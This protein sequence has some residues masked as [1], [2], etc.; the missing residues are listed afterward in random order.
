MRRSVNMLL[1]AV[2]SA[3]VMPV[4]AQLSEYDQNKPLGWGQTVTGSNDENPIT[5]TTRSALIS[6]L[7]GTAAK[8]IYVK[9][10]IE[11]TGI[12]TINGA[13]NK[14]I[15]GLPGS[16]LVNSEH[17][18]DSE[19]EHDENSKTD[20]VHVAAQSHSGILRLANCKNIILRNLTF[21]SA[22]AYDINGN[23]NLW[24]TGSSYIWVDHCDF[25]DGVDGNFDCSQGSDNI[26]VTW[27]RFRY[28]I[29]PWPG[30]CGGSD[31]HC[32]SDLWGGSD[33]ETASAGKLNTTFANCWWDEGC[34]E[35]MPRVRHGKVHLV[36]CLY[37]C[38]GNNY[39]VGAGYNSNLYVEKCAFV[40]VRDPWK[41]YATSGS[42]TNYNIT[43]TGN[44]GAD[45][46]QSRSGS[47]DYFI[48]TDYYTLDSYD[49]ALV[50]SVVSNEEN[51]AGATLDIKE[52]DKLTTGISQTVTSG[53]RITAT[54]YFTL[55]GMEASQP[56][57]G[58]NIVQEK[59][60]DGTVRARKVM[61]R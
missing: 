19:A 18:P 42:Y 12:Q 54:R 26:S 1:V 53:A 23:D 32:Y 25:Q 11:F 47:A 33:G 27:C 30:G 6:A 15:Y 3:M 50:Q 44:L 59:L 7:S 45:D 61:V 29:A 14:T 57:S 46:E 41:C 40:N 55:S 13:Q 34:L 24:I 51:G 28:L 39:C 8:T 10:E 37:T 36:N 49:A 17:Y 52:G 38:T 43:M 5:V 2:L 4:K 22:G 21:K 58:L 9:G 16:A 48:P 56:Q 35:R 20:Q 31:A 60:S